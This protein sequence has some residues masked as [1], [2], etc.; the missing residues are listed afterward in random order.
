MWKWSIAALL[1]MCVLSVILANLGEEIV[2]YQQEEI[3]EKTGE[4]S[5]KEG[6]YE[7]TISYNGNNTTISVEVYPYEK[8]YVLKYGNTT[9]YL[10]SGGD[11]KSFMHKRWMIYLKDNYSWISKTYY[12][13]AGMEIIGEK[14]NY[15]VLGKEQIENRT[16]Y[17]VEIKGKNFE[18][19]VWISESERILVQAEGEN[20]KITLT[21]WP[22]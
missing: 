16:T 3:G 14:M 7:Y 11:S 2:A 18:E 20:Y 9:E 22:K 4:L 1:I 5:L 12:R 15:T 21:T 17:V 10:E 8:G 19:T 6:V 13:A